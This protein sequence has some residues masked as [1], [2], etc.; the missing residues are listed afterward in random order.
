VTG[1][2]TDAEAGTPI[3]SFKFTIGHSQPW[4]PSDQ[5]PMWDMRSKTGSNGFYKVV[6]E[7]EQVPYLRIEADGYETVEAELQLTNG[8]K[9]FAISP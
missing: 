7:E 2:V 3:A 5:T 6:I 8:S 4:N 1:S 9:G